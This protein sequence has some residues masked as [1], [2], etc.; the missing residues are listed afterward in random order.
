[1]TFPF[2]PVILFTVSCSEIN[3]RDGKTMWRNRN[4]W[5]I[6]SGEFIAGV[7]LWIGIIGNLEFMQE[8]VPSDFVKSLILASGILAGIMASP[9]AGRMIDTYRKK[10]ILLCSGFFRIISVLFMFIALA[11]DSVAWMVVFLIAMQLSAAFYFP[12]LQAAIPLI[13][14][15]N[16]LLAVNGAHM[17]AGTLARIAGTAIGGS[18][19]L[20][21]SLPMLYLCSIFAYIL[22]FIFTFFLRIDESPGRAGQKADAKKER[23]FQ[24][25]MPAIKSRPAI[26]MTLIIVLMPLLMIGG[27]NLIVI[28]ISEIYG[29]P[30]VKGLVYTTE[31][32]SFMLGAYFVKKISARRSPFAILGFFSLLM[33]LGEILLFFV[34]FKILLFLSFVL[35]GFSIG[36]IF[37]TAATIFQTKM[38]KEY[39]GRFFSFRNMLER[40]GFQVVLLGTGF[41]LD[42]IG[43]PCMVLIYGSL[44]LLITVLFS[45]KLRKTG[46]KR[47]AGMLRF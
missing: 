42:T 24:E 2:F 10:T 5:I 1:M 4:V 3:M 22:L 32:I 13:V 25:V 29:D 18:L 27:F 15:E 39:H 33:S 28:N 31:G 14:K 35:F 37:P 9:L 26:L 23:G 41:L 12:A 30:S 20:F 46:A 17:N 45:A 36:C 6:I 47:E 34:H 8:R 16:E 40:I 11:A 44:S 21:L 19:L 38:P 43:L 7:G